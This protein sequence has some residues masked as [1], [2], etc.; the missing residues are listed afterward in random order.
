MKKRD[1]NMIVSMFHKRVPEQAIAP[2]EQC[3]QKRAGLVDKMPGFRGLEVLRHGNEKG[4]YVVLTHWETKEDFERW[5][6]S[7]EFQAGHARTG[8]SGVAGGAVEFY[9]VLVS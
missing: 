5:A 1:A 7:P 6:R 9:E 8:E 2:F 4:V 3:W